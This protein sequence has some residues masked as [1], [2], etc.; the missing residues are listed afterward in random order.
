MK[1]TMVRF[2]LLGRYMFSL[3][4]QLQKLCRSVG[5]MHTQWQKKWCSNAL[6]VFAHIHFL[7]KYSK[8]KTFG[9]FNCHPTM[10]W[11]FLICSKCF[12]CI[13]SN[14][15]KVYRLWICVGMTF[16]HG[17]KV[18]CIFN[19]LSNLAKGFFFHGVAFD[20]CRF[21]TFL[22][23]AQLASWA[24]FKNVQ[25]LHQSNVTPWKKNPL[26]KTIFV[27]SWN[28]EKLSKTKFKSSLK[29]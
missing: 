18:L 20:W 10:S 22:N 26:V 3:N 27:S 1:P 7:L 2:I 23:S 21:C 25:N 6:N 12:H 16:Y 14:I 9:C 13:E 28:K 19:T 11:W 15:R 8:K 29:N 17:K 24:K 5:E 4:Q